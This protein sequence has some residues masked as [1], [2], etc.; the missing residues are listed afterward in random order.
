MKTLNWAPVHSC[1]DAATEGTWQISVG[2]DEEKL[3]PLCFAAGK[4][5]KKIVQL[6]LKLG[7]PPG[8]KSDHWTR[9]F[10]P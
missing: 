6:L 2:K 5:K 9:Q 7:I 3:D 10:F 8:L 1:E 4:Q